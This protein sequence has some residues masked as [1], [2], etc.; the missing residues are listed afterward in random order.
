M[1]MLPDTDKRLSNR[2]WKKLTPAQAKR[3]KRNGDKV[4]SEVLGMVTF[5]Y[6]IK[7]SGSDIWIRRL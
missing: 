6:E 2:G 3:F 1:S 7:A 5:M 4:A